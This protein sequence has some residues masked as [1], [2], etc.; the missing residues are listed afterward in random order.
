M[1]DKKCYCKDCK[2]D[3]YMPYNRN[4]CIWCGSKSIKIRSSLYA[5]KFYEKMNFKKSTGLMKSK[6][7][8]YQPMKKLL[9]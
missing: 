6:G 2:K 9:N 4:N 3:F 1:K 5:V 8:N 7:R